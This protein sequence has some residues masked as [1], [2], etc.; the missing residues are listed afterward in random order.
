MILLNEGQRPFLEFLRNLTPQAL[1]AST[2]LLLGVRLDFGRVDLSN[3]FSTLSFFLCVAFACL[4]F[5]ANMNQYFDALLASVDRFGTLARRLVRL[6]VTR[7]WALAISLRAIWR[8][9]PSV[10]LDLVASYALVNVA[11]VAIATAALAS[12]RSALK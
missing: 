6:G 5:F 3:W 11:W 7:R 10:F 4:A 8:R 2:A 9:R 1:L 12:A